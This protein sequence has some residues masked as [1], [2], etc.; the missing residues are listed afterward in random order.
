MSSGHDSDTKSAVD[1]DPRVAPDDLEDLRAFLN[2]DNRFYGVDMLRLHEHRLLFFARALRD[3]DIGDIDE[4]GWAR[5]IELR[6]AIRAL[7]AGEPGAAGRLTE[8]AAGHALR[9][10]F[11]GEAGA[12][13]RTR[14]VP[15]GTRPELPIAAAVLTALQAPCRTVGCP[16]SASASARTAGGSTTTGRRT[17]RPGGAPP[18]R[19]A[20]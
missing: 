15:A 12:A 4:R 17:A 13:P 5:L 20:T 10:S 18:T 11:Q 14:L 9:V 16:G 2:S 3:F 19:A 7:V 1:K 8:V 6:D